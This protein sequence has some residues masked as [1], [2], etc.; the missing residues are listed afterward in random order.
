M[1]RQWIP[2]LCFLCFFLLIASMNS[3]AQSP[4]VKLLRKKFSAQELY[5]ELKS[6]G[7][8]SYQITDISDITEN[9]ITDTVPVTII[10]NKKLNKYSTEDIF[11]AYKV[12]YG[13]DDRI[14]FFQASDPWKKFAQKT[15]TIVK[16]SR[17]KQNGDYF[18]IVPKGLLGEL[19]GFCNDEK[20]FSNPVLGYCSG[21]AASRRAIITAGHCIANNREF[22]DSIAFVFDF[23]YE[24]DKLI[25]K[26]IPKENVFFGSN[27]IK[28]VK[29]FVEGSDF[30]IIEVTR[31]IPDFR[32]SQ[33][34]QAGIVSPGQNLIA[35][36]Y[37]NGT[38]VK[39][40]PNGKVY[41]NDADNFF[42]TNLDT[43]EG[44]SGGPVFDSTTGLV[45]G[46]IKGGN[47]DFTTITISNTALIC[48]K[49]IKCP[50]NIGNQC[51]GERVIR[52]S[53]YVM[54]IPKK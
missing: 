19:E 25:I 31:D 29:S 27:I 45:E 51:L 30:C 17:L 5:K 28:Y 1:R 8:E 36:G 38:P 23:R 20:F 40:S 44:N 47:K 21:Y 53:S 12:Y 22:L 32:I 3:Y 2:D 9:T 33:T 6:R 26:D 10:R 46:I 42:I 15:L 11:E 41:N 14:D 54:F 35:V 39:I 7:E 37:P 52:A 4:D 50:E 18:Q 34:R 13:T 43:Y 24:N 16:R 48:K 49:S